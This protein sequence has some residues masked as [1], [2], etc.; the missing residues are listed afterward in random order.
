MSEIERNREDRRPHNFNARWAF[1]GIVVLVII[2]LF[3]GEDGRKD[4]VF[5]KIPAKTCYPHRS[6]FSCWN[7]VVGNK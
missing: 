2:F 1:K 5:R 4:S 3:D 6:D 7:I